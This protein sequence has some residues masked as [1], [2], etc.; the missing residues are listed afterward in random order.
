VAPSRRLCRRPVEDRQVDAMGCVGPCYPSFAVFNVLGPTGIVVIY[1]RVDGA[2]CHFS[3]L[4]F[5]LFWLSLGEVSRPDLISRN[6][7]QFL[8]PKSVDSCCPSP[9]FLLVSLACVIQ[10]P[11]SCSVAV[12]DR[13][14]VSFTPVG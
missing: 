8:F 9:F 14:A 7:S 10:S 12:Q 1:P 3:I 11:S 13:P 2:L 6:Q 5:T 4:L